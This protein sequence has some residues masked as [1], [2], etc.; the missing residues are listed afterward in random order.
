MNGEAPSGGQVVP[1]PRRPTSRVEFG[2]EAILA[3]KGEFAIDIDASAATSISTHIS[4]ASRDADDG[5]TLTV[6]GKTGGWNGFS[7]LA[8]VA[9]ATDGRTNRFPLSA[10]AWTQSGFAH[11]T[12][13][14]FDAATDAFTRALAID[15]TARSARLG[16]ARVL[17][18]SG[19]SSAA[20]MILRTLLNEL[21]NDVEVRVALAVA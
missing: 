10:A 19:A 15:P 5:T 4:I 7:L 17:N 13:G 1:V 9:H 14:Q 18:T 16:Y 20:L 12:T 6:S 3:P 2:S 21:P 11:L 8:E